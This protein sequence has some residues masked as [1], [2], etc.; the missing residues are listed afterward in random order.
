[1]TTEIRFLPSRRGLTRLFSASVFSCKREAEASHF[2][3]IVGMLSAVVLVPIIVS[4]S[5]PDLNYYFRMIA[6]DI[7][8]H[9]SQNKDYEIK[10]I[11]EELV[12]KKT[13]W[14]NDIDRNGHMNNAR[15]IR[16]LNFSRRRLFSLN[17]IWP[18]LRQKGMNLIVQSQMIRYRKDMKCWQNYIIR[19]KVIYWSDNPKDECFYL[20]SR[21]EDK[22]GFVIAIHH[23]KYRI[24]GP[25]CCDLKPSSLI[26]EA[27]LI[28]ISTDYSNYN[29]ESNLPPDYLVSWI[30]SM[31]ISSE[32][33]NP[34]KLT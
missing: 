24:I 5:L 3:M 11:Y 8:A 26:R 16:E 19:S 4:M 28:P 9:S 29:N 30:D 2:L 27:N 7:Q 33:L 21:F 12:E 13:V 6:I 23:L 14:P 25:K 18:I 20:E 1:M 22:T 10:S 32:A 34:K 31:K 15:Y 17:R